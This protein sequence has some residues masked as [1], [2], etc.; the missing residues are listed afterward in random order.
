[1]ERKNKLVKKVT[2]ELVVKIN[3]VVTIR[4]L[5]D[6]I[7]D[8]LG[9]VNL[10]F[11]RDPEM[12]L[13]EDESS[14][15]N[16][17]TNDNKKDDTKNKV[18]IITNK[19]DKEL[20]GCDDE[21]ENVNTK[22]E[23]H[24]NQTQSTDLS[25]LSNQDKKVEQKK[26]DFYGI[27]IVAVNTSK[28]LIIVIKLDSKKFGK[29][30]VSKPV[31]DVGI[32]LS[33]LFKLI[34][35]LDKDDILTMSIDSDDKQ[36]L[37]LD[38]ENEVRNSRTRNRLKTLDIDKKTYKIPD[39]KFD[40]VVTMDSSEFHRVCKDLALL[41][42]YV[43]I[44]CKE[45]SITFMSMCDSSDKSIT[46]DATGKNGVK[47]KPLV[48]GKDTVVQGI[49]ELKYFTMFQK[50]S[51]LCQNIQI[52][53]R[54]NYPIFI[55]YLIASLGQILVGIVPVNDK[56]INNNNFSDD[57]EEYSDDEKI[58]MKGTKSKDKKINDIEEID[59]IEDIEDIEDIA[60]E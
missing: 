53:L 7:K 39:T 30:K 17:N 31:F 22:K 25:K 44:E 36:R 33:S 32:N 24:L 4:T 47:I 35:S 8:F 15:L 9:D 45:N 42:D 19:P 59:D 57:E 51:N 12:E 28:S 2:K 3:D 20:L 56:N 46:I 6:V 37:I 18:K 49:F 14:K 11:K 58:K 23:Q 34:R 54:N 38:V 5:V 13:E 40:M 60:D 27:K 10:E 16:E 41:S 48:A 1:M 26:N 55:K 21:D 43:D 29:F 50:C 52:Y